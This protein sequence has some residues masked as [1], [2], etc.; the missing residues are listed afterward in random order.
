MEPTAFDLAGTAIGVV[1]RSRV[2]D[3]SA[4]RRRRRDR[5]P[6]VVRAPR[7]RLLARPLAADL[8]GPR[9]DR[10]VPGAAAPDAR[11]RRRRPRRSP[12]SRSP[13]LATLGEVLLTPTRDLRPGDPRGPGR[14]RC[15]R[16]TT[17]TDSPTSPAAACPGNVP[18]ALP[19][20]LARSPRPDALGDALG[21][22][23]VRGPRRPGRPRAAVDVQR[24]DRDD[25]RRRAGRRRG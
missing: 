16:A 15:R 10:A 7:E 22:A 13:A 21:H 23:P 11:R 8:V 17:S 25:R 19:A 3:G 20:H 5:R 4:V 2:I 6:G 18:R 1:E 12:A 9:P 24:R 14:A